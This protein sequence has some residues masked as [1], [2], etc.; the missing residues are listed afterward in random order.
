VAVSF[1]GGRTK[2]YHQPVASHW[3]SP[4]PLVSSTNKIGG[5][6]KTTDLRQ[7]GGFLNSCCV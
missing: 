7:V 1:I 3:F 5:P 2:E 4:G 6:M